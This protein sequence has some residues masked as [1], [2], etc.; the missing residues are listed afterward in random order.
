MSKR[1]AASTGAWANRIVRSGVQRADQFIG[2]PDNWRKHPRAQEAALVG[3]LDKIGWVQEVIV[4]KRSGYIIDGHLRV[5]AAMSKDEATPVPFKEV[6]VSEAE[7]AT[8]LAS[9]DPLSALAVTDEVKY[10]EL[11]GLLPEDLAALAALAKGSQETAETLVQFTAKERK[12]TVV[13]EC[14]DADAQTQLINRL[15]Q[16]GYA[17]RAGR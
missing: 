9:L 6:D 16:E 8:L 17:C 12:P 11:V 5:L 13:V 2:A 3:V 15:V 14:A 4:S 7:E 1:R 10:A